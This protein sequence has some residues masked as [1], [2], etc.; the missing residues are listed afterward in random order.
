MQR[1]ANSNKM[2]G[3]SLIELLVVVTIV[4]ILAS[5]AI[6]SYRQYVIRSHRPD[7]TTMLLR[8]QS[9]QEK[10]FLQNLRYSDDLT[11]APPAGLGM[12]GMS[13]EQH[14]DVALT[15][16]AANMTY[17]ATATPHSGDGQVDDTKCTSF[18]VNQA[19]TRGATGAVDAA[20]YCWR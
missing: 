12:T 16:G 1:S 13:P 4:G 2:L 9:A 17:V 7:A 19:G 8:I 18:T 3:F 6:P 15:M 14:Y 11:A 5:I 20:T 10:F